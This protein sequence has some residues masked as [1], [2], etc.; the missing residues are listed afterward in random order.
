MLLIATGR[1][2]GRANAQTGESEL[3]WTRGP[4]LP[5]P[6]GWAGVYA[7]VVDDRL[8]VGGGANFPSGRPWEGAA[9]VWH[10][11]LWVLR[12]SE[13]SWER[14]S[15]R[16]PRPSAYGI[17]LPWKAGTLWMGGAD[18]QQHFREV[19]WLHSDQGQLQFESL[20]AL[21]EPCAFSCG[22]ILDGVLYVAGGLAAP[23]AVRPL[24]NF[25]ALQLNNLDAGWQEQEPWPGPPRMLAVAAVQS[26]ALFLISGVDLVQVEGEVRRVYLRD[27]Y[28]FSPAEGW[29][30]IADVP[31]PTA[32][33]PTPA[34]ALGQSHLAILGGDDGSLASETALL[35]DAHPGFRREILAYHTITDRWRTIGTLPVDPGPDPANQPEAG[36][37][38]PVT[39]PTVFWQNA[40]HLP[41]GE[42]RPGVRTPQL[43]QL[44]ERR[45]LRPF[46]GLDSVVLSIYLVILVAIGWVC[47]R[48]G[49]TTD[50]FFRG[51]QR[52]PWWAAGISIFGTQ[53]SAITFMAIPAKSYST[54][55]VFLIANF[56]IAA[57]APFVVFWYL[58]F[59]RRLNLTTAYEYL[60]QR[61]GLITRLLGS[62]SFVLFQLGRMGIV[63][64]L[65]ALATSAV[66]GINIYLC[67]CVMG[68]LAT[69]YTVL[70]GIEA[71]IWTDV[72]QVVV[73]L[74]G[75]VLSLALISWQ[76]ESGPLAW[77]PEA[78]EAGKLHTLNLNWDIT[79]TALWVVVV[80]NLFAVLVPYT[81]DQ[82]VVQRYL[83]TPT[84][85][86]AARAI[87]T[88]ALL[89]IPA[90]LLFF[91]LGTALW[92]FYRQNPEKLAVSGR[93][94]D[95]FPWFI[96]EELP[97]GVTGLVFAGLFAAAMSS[98][99]SSMNSI[100][101]T[102]TVDL[103]RL[104]GNL[105][106]KDCLRWARGFT[107]A[108]GILGSGMA[109]YMARQSSASMMDL[110]VK[111]LGLFG[112]GLAGL[113]AAGIFTQR[114]HQRGA[115][116]GFAGS[117]VALYLVQAYALVHFFL[118]AAVGV[119]C[120]VLIGW[121][122]SLIW[123]APPQDLKGLT[124]LTKED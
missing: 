99:D 54:N 36:I 77:I 122:V 121:L 12:E 74:G 102:L 80:G 105:S 70:G 59:F 123:P 98:L 1:A 52:I 92:W 62:A 15:L 124:L 10:D 116:A 91:T 88:N 47:A 42:A 76:S 118:Y 23:K 85:K 100:A 107:V 34:P 115:L 120:C 22:A 55:W 78:L 82:T 51:G 67:I 90:T 8:Y 19:H 103:R 2:D 61:F 110:Y 112:G 81:S 16:L 6:I 113:F 13:G 108:L 46:R 89:S 69:V 50:D 95:I 5:D 93:T 84:A 43:L 27:A 40:W 68:A 57:V 4:P 31:Q 119:L 104:R 111:V 24:H 32:A 94:D 37:W 48:R 39:T 35:K 30:R 28:Q 83:T 41:S 101:A 64:Y 56:M 3:S 49:K 11:G 17:C 86:G 29:R 96:A 72:L 18:A 65:P 71:V 87:W 38:A 20:P 60:E 114:I 106:D 58:P 21:P 109:L 26:E 25:W 53:L 73:L 45:A 66:T 117:A 79:T 9:K 75:A 97:A 44:K 63:L 14:V 7:G 33:A